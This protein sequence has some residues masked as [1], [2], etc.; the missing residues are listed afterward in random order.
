[1]PQ[2]C[3]EHHSIPLCDIALPYHLQICV[4]FT[5]W[6]PYQF[7]LNM[8]GL[9]DSRRMWTTFMPSAWKPTRPLLTPP[10]P[11]CRSPCITIPPMPSRGSACR[12]D[13]GSRTR[14]PPICRPRFQVL[15]WCCCHS[16]CS[17]ERWRP[18]PI[19]TYSADPGPR[20]AAWPNPVRIPSAGRHGCLRRHPAGRKGGCREGVLSISDGSL[21]HPHLT[22]PRFIHRSQRAWG[23]MLGKLVGGSWGAEGYPAHMT[24]HVRGALFTHPFALS[25]LPAPLCS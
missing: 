18:G 4:S 19:P 20:E 7:C 22:S 6:T 24:V 9:H 14:S 5:L 13:A 8:S 2:Y 15:G 21:G 16:R 17:G 23:A 11:R 3:H 10:S 1:M 12:R 25:L